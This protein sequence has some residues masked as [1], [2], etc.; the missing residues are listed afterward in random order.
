MNTNRNSVVRC[1]KCIRF[2]YNYFNCGIFKAGKLL[3]LFSPSLYQT[4][5]ITASIAVKTITA[6]VG[7]VR[8]FLVHMRRVGV[9]TP[10]NCSQRRVMSSKNNVNPEMSCMVVTTLARVSY[11]THSCR[12]EHPSRHKGAHVVVFQFVQQ[13]VLSAVTHDNDSLPTHKHK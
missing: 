3:F 12:V 4:L 5:R 10:K 8:S 7:L 6:I 2:C 1:A 13:R 11:A 9:N